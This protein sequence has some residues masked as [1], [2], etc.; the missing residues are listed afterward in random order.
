MKADPDVY[1]KEELEFGTKEEEKKGEDDGDKQAERKLR[2]MMR[3]GQART[4]EAFGES[5]VIAQDLNK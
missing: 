5:I 3:S 2:E 4:G 1:S